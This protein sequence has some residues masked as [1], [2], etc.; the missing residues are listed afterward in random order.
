[1][2]NI[3]DYLLEG[4]TAE[5]HVWNLPNIK[6]QG[7]ERWIAS[8]QGTKLAA[9]AKKKDIATTGTFFCVSTI[10]PGQPRKKQ[11]AREMR[12]LHADVDFK[13]IDLAPDVIINLIKLLD[14]PPT[15]IHH[16]G[17]GLHCFWLLDVAAGPDQMDRAEI[18][19]RK[20][21]NHVGGDMLVAHR[22]AL[23]RV[24]GSHNSKRG[25]WR[26]VTVLKEG[27]ETYT[28]DQLDAWLAPTTPPVMVRRNQDQNPFLRQ[29]QEQGF[30]APID[31]EQRLADMVVGGDGETGVH[32]TQLSC[33]ASLMHAG[34][35]IE[36]AVTMVLDATREL[37]GTENWNW[38][39][40]EL[41]IREMC[42]DAIK[43]FQKEP[44]RSTL[45]LHPLE[46][47]LR[48]LVNAPPAS[49]VSLADARKER[50][51]RKVDPDREA[52]KDRAKQRLSSKKKNEHVVIGMGILAKLADDG[53]EIMYT[54]NQCWIYSG[55]VWKAMDGDEEKAWASV[56]VEQ[57]CTELKLVSNTKI[58]NETRAWLQR[59]PDLHKKDIEW[60]AHGCIATTNGLFDWRTGSVTRISPDDYVTR[61]IDCDYDEQADC[62]VWLEMLYDDYG[63]TEDTIEF[64]QDLLGVS[65]LS[66][67]PR[68]L[69]RALV[70]LGPS[71]S[72]KSNI[73][74]A[75]AGLISDDHNPT[76]LDTLNGTHG[77]MQFLK[78]VPW[79]LHEAFEQSRW[80]MSANAKALLSGDVIHVNI[81]NGPLVPLEFKQPIFWG[82]NV[83]PQFKEASRAM[84]NRL[85]IVKMQK[86]FD[87]HRITGTALKAV[88]AGY[89]TPAEL[90]LATE[91]EGLLAWAVDGLK[92]AMQRGHFVFTNEMTDSLSAMR[93]DS[94]MAVGFL[95]AC[96]IYDPESYITT[97]DAYA[98]FSIW[99]NDHR[100]GPTPSVD[101]LGRAMASSSD[102][103][104]LTGHKVSHVRVYAG[105]RLNDD[106]LGCWEGYS[107]SQRAMNSGQR[108]S[109]SAADVNKVLPG[110]ALQSSALQAMQEAH[111]ANP[112]A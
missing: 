63:F 43:K 6:G 56:L 12:F 66:K 11:H 69:M 1:M 7:R 64:L 34:V 71:N 59:Q 96:C 29:A 82:S 30:R 24:P 110:T 39:Q 61:V 4:T 104:L 23:L 90:V 108:V 9:W 13:N 97:A 78:P 57:G 36:D 18:I 52:A 92:R 111:A 37:G 93:T 40:E 89:N 33:T 35:D 107:T 65:L 86:T 80:E 85:A 112:P 26:E 21:A 58:V 8:R 76:P 102:A 67:K 94:N 99:H 75:F 51:E 3:F 70:L 50:E 28:L 46:P 5:V 109:G 98:A 72:G 2:A 15:L 84:E 19:L 45:T 87:P 100:S 60:D 91:K 73:L 62:P 68:S 42:T 17:N 41:T 27:N 22:V 44:S 88:Q 47:S 48:E 32:Q 83:P 106:G 55:G 74:N 20:L 105:I 95:E 77:L 79:V 53:Q 14:C 101:S 103:R 81:K 25:E 49:V 31:V 54:Q 10:A 16:T 38:V